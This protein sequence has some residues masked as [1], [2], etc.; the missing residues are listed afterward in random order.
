MT[1]HHKNR[2]SAAQHIR[3]NYFVSSKQ[4]QQRVRN[5]PIPNRT[6]TAPDFDACWLSTAAGGV[7][8][9]QEIVDRY[10]GDD[11]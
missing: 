2:G 8:E 5:L 10:H 7:I 6:A 11:R 1:F 9:F 3:P 4:R